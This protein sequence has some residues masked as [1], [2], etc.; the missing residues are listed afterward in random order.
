MVK[1]IVTGVAGRMGGRIVH[2]MEA[3]AGIRLAGAVESRRATRRWAKMWARWWGSPPR[4]S[5]WWTP[6]TRSCPRGRW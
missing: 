4:G 6:W 5:R 3:D 2:L 1:A